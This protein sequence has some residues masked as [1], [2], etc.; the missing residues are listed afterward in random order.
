MCSTILNVGADRRATFSIRQ[1]YYP[2]KFQNKFECSLAAFRPEL[3]R[4]DKA[5]RPG[6][7]GS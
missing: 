3:A 7:L 4:A 5:S 1:P 6:S 2:L